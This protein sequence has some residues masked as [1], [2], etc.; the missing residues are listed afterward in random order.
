MGRKRWLQLGSAL[1][2]AGVLIVVFGKDA[3]YSDLAVSLARDPTNQVAPLQAVQR[4]QLW[5]SVGGFTA[6]IGLIVVTT[7]HCSRWFVKTTAP[8]P[9]ATSTN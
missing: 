7:S 1:I 5:T 6:G 2:V 4:V 3:A 9:D 8:T